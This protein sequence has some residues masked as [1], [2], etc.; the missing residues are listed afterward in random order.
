MCILKEARTLKTV[1]TQTTMWNNR[2]SYDE[3]GKTNLRQLIA[4]GK[5]NLKIFFS[6]ALGLCDILMDYSVKGMLNL[7][8]NPNSIFIDLSSNKVTLN[9]KCFKSMN[10][11]ENYGGIEG[12]GRDAIPYISPELS[13]MMNRTVDYRSD[14]YSLGAVLYEMLTNKP[15]FEVNTL[16][17]LIYCHTAKMPI[18]PHRINKNIPVP[19]SNIVMRLLLK[20][21]EERYRTSWGIKHDLERCLKEFNQKG[22]VDKFKLGYKDIPSVF[23]IP[24]KDY[25]RRS[26]VKSILSAFNRVAGGAAEIIVINGENGMGKSWLVER[27][28][29]III[30]RGGYF[31]GGKSNQINLNIPYESIIQALRELVQKILSESLEEMN[32]IRNELM[33]VL[34]NNIQVMLDLIPELKFVLGGKSQAVELSS[35]ESEY[36]FNMLFQRFLKVF[37][38]ENHPLVIF[39]DDVQWAHPAALRL[40]T[41]L[42][43]HYDNKYLLVI[44]GYRGIISTRTKPKDDIEFLLQELKENTKVTKLSLKPFDFDELT[45]ILSDALHCEAEQVKELTEVVLNKTYGN[46]LFVDQLMKTLYERELIT[47]D[48]VNKSWVWDMEKIAKESIPDNVVDIIVQKLMTLP[49]ST[50]KL[51]GLAA[52]LGPKFDIQTLV[53]VS[54]SSLTDTLDCL[55]SAI[56]AGLIEVVGDYPTSILDVTLKQLQNKIEVKFVHD[57]IQQSAYAVI[58]KDNHAGL[59][60]KVGRLLLE[61]CSDEELNVKI[62]DIVNHLNFAKSLLN[63][64]EKRIKLAGLNLIAGRKAKNANDYETAVNYFNEGFQILADN[65]WE[66]HYNLT[67][68]LRIECAEC[69]FLL[70]K[71]KNAEKSLKEIFEYSR[72]IIEKM[73]AYILQ[74]KIFSSSEMYE[75]AVKVAME[76]LK[77]CNIYIDYKIDNQEIFQELK[78]IRDRLPGDIE[79]FIF[80]QTQLKDPNVLYIL[81]LIVELSEAA[82]FI[83]SD[84]WK[85]CI[86][87]IVNMSLQYGNSSASALGYA[88]LGKLITEFISIK[89]GYRL[90]LL[91]L[92][93]ANVYEDLYIRTR[94]F[95]IF[96]CCICPLKEDYSISISYLEKSFEYAFN[97][98]NL[99][100]AA[101]AASSEV[102]MKLLMGKKLTGIRNEMDQYLSSIKP[103]GE[104]VISNIIFFVNCV[105]HAGEG[106]EI[107]RIEDLL[108]ML[109]KREEKILR[110]RNK[111]LIGLYYFAKMKL[112]SVLGRFEEAVEIVFYMDEFFRNSF[113]DLIYCSFTYVGTLVVCRF[114]DEERGKFSSKH[115][116]ILRNNIIELERLSSYNS[117]NFLARYLLINAELSRIEGKFWEAQIFY[118]KSL[119]QC[120]HKDYIVDAA[121]VCESAARFCLSQGLETSAIAYVN[122]AK[123]YYEASDSVSQFMNLDNKFRRLIGKV[124]IDEISNKPVNIHPEESITNI[125]VNTA[126]KVSKII[127]E[128]IVMERLLIKL[129]NIAM[130]SSGAQ[131]G[132]LV[133]YEN[134]RLIIEVE[135]GISYEKETKMRH[136]QIE[137]FNN[138]AKSVIY[139]ALRT[140]ESVI[141]NNAPADSVFSSDNYIIKN[142]PQSIMCI[143]ILYNENVLGFIYLENTLA[144]NVFKSTKLEVLKLISSQA[145][146]AIQNAKM[147]KKVKELND[148]LENKVAERTKAIEDA[149]NKLENEIENSKRLKAALEY[150]KLKTEFFAN[151]SHELRTPLNVILTSNQMCALTLRDLKDKLLKDKLNKYINLTKQNCYRLIRLTNNLIDITKIDAGYIK[152]SLCNTEIVKIIEDITLSVV[153]YAKRKDIELIFD[154]EVEEKYLSCDP[155]MIERIMLNLLTNAIK[156]TDSGGKIE[157]SVFDFEYSIQIQVTDSGTG[158]PK[159]KINSIFDRFVQVDKSL[160]RQCEGSGIGLSLVKSLVEMH[161]G[162][163]EVR[164]TVGEGSKFIINLPAQI[165]DGEV[166]AT[167]DNISN[168]NKVERT[169]IEFSDIYF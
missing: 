29:Q 80:E 95:Y 138:I 168:E 56:E 18:S 141:L 99:K 150:D 163:I 156:F 46:P 169:N 125:D 102:L 79:D 115:L 11:F 85:N 64:E 43:K 63:D 134:E 146:I 2:I 130:E 116:D 39:L 57:C 106:S 166:C 70:G 153:E 49:D 17:E 7:R 14:F 30:S 160:S 51:L 3:N 151:I 133:L 27:S 20:N 25:G 109:I 97:L 165:T 132:F 40:I 16:S 21:P 92:N 34:G 126:I 32:I 129:I 136:I 4:E 118:E 113:G 104:S 10:E 167:L 158:I 128:E 96:G 100:Y 61:N 69:E 58:W 135:C 98:G 149:L 15:P 101:L 127:S 111:S 73:Q 71:K 86:I 114:I 162:T 137:N 112:L 60:L 23:E 144:S 91:S 107:S 90:G 110:F 155:D 50:K 62:F 143:P 74:V 9:N 93:L 103:K 12:I 157:V 38:R 131:K 140:S 87:K 55:N 35:R 33:E 47:F 124:E 159:D 147:F 1:S 142:K 48:Y 148:S 152:M 89:E 24:K 119:E 108:N 105:L 5:I 145:S 122:R 6:V 65:K 88:G 42:F 78:K 76:G 52:C 72:T 161:N 123:V 120:I 75:D 8:I 139:Y 22:K 36:R 19:L 53:V 77:L 67:F 28:K 45:K 54:E 66:K 13:G 59:H 82:V 117:D 81:K 37:S 84:L 26:E 41:N 121:L 94:V 68:Q 44:L 31:V 83:N 154:T 164:S